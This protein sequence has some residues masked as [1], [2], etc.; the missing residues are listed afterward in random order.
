MQDDSYY[1]FGMVVESATSSP[2][3]KYLYNKKELQSELGQY[4]YG[5]RFYDPVIGRWTSVDPLA[6][7]NRR[8]SP[9]NYGEDDPI[10]KTD[11]DGTETTKIH[12]KFA[13]AADKTAYTSTVNKI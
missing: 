11:P 2:P 3:N 10:G 7:G 6:E 8:W 13:T 5:A 9:Y 1:P 4:D 12:L